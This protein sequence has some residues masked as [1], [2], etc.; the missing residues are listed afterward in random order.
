MKLWL[1][2]RSACWCTVACLLP[3]SALAAPTTTINAIRLWDAPDHTRVVLDLNRAA[4]YR[5]FSLHSPERVVIDI[6]HARLASSPPAL[7]HSK[8]SVVRAIRAGKRKSGTLRIVLDVRARLGLHSANLKPYR[9]KPHRLVIDLLRHQKQTQTTQAIRSNTRKAR[10]RRITIA[11]DAGHGGEDPGAIGRHGLQEKRVTLAIAKALADQLNHTAG[12]H[13]FLTRRGDY[14]VPLKKRI[15]IARN[16]HADVMIS[17]HADA[18]KSRR[19]KG[20]SVYTLSE[21]GA[22]PDRVATALAAKEN[23]ADAVAGIIH[24][25]QVDDPMVNSILGDMARTDSLNSSL[26]LAEQIIRQIARVAPIKY[27]RPKRARFVVL[28]AMEIPSVLVETDYISNPSRERLL[29]SRRHQHKLARAIV[30]GSVAFLQRMGR[31]RTTQSS[32][33]AH[34]KMANL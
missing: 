20:A 10:N 2:I 27:D 15:R 8:Q 13:A 1:I 21:R 34:A 30:D 33:N 28:G 24:S 9:G 14:F 11:V 17:I 23:A 31:L 18:V 25:T 7:S 3:V 19:V 5:L 12:I 4:K 32:T 29:K 26:M 6:D 16:H 22:T